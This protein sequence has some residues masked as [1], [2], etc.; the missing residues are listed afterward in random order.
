MAQNSILFTSISLLIFSIFSHCQA[1]TSLEDLCDV[2][3]HPT[4]CRSVL[5]VGSPGSVSGFANIVILKSLE[6]SKHLLASLD[7]HHP[8]SGPL[9]DCQ[10]LA[11]LTVDQLTRVNV[12]KD[13]VVGTSEVNDLLTLLSASLTN[14]E[15]CLGSF[16]D[17]TGESS[18]NFV[19]DHQDI[20]TPVA[21]G[22]KL[23][24]V[25]LALSKEAWPIAS[26][27][28]G[29]KPPPRILTEEKKSSSPDVSYAKV[30]KRERMIYERVK[31]LGRKLLQ[32]SFLSTDRI[33]FAIFSDHLTYN[34]DCRK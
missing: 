23:I 24:S 29:R 27:A 7:P 13:T 21:D 6:A 12:I 28:S 20:L 2:T 17:V 26:D 25:S 4:V 19:K 11:G 18:E 15:T 9:D 3:P 34:R 10:L 30:T 14:Y 33:D 32:V 31:V 16:H 1:L 5:P 22:I 8:A